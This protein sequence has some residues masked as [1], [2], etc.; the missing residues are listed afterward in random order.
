M[1]DDKV[2]EFM[3]WA[4]FSAA[5]HRVSRKVITRTVGLSACAL[6]VLRDTFVDSNLFLTALSVV[7]NLANVAMLDNLAAKDRDRFNLT[8]WAKRQHRVYRA[9]NLTIC[10]LLLLLGI[11]DLLRNFDCFLF[12]P[13]FYL[14][15]AYEWPLPPKK[16]KETKPV[17]QPEGVYNAN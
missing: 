4:L 10:V 17:L 12:I 16:V 11:E 1:I 7:C 9:F 14:L 5:K 13:L 2:F 8:Q 3:D 15:F 6:V